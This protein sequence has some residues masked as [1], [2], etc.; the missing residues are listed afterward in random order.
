MPSRTLQATALVLFVSFCGVEVATAHH[1]PRLGRFLSRDPIGEKGESHLHAMVGNNPVNRHDPHGLAAAPCLNP[2][3]GAGGWVECWRGR[4]VPC[5]ALPPSRDP[6][7]EFGAVAC[8]RA[9]EE[10]HARHWFLR[11]SCKCVPDGERPRMPPGMARND[12]CACGTPNAD[13][14]GRALEACYRIQDSGRQPVCVV[15]VQRCLV[16]QCKQMQENG[17]ALPSACR[18]VSGATWP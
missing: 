3:R 1:C 11:L 14:L 10:C 5:T 9:H 16:D 8:D 12:E 17:C 4:I 7:D 6:A 18:L 15:I 2:P 13:C